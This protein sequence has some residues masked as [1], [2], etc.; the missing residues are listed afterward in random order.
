[1]LYAWHPRLYKGKQMG[2]SPEKVD[3]L[4]CDSLI[5]QRIVEGEENGFPTAWYLY[6]RR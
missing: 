2:I 5:K 3:E 4:L 6:R 1:M